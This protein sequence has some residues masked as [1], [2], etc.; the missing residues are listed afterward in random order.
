MCI[1]VIKSKERAYSVKRA[2]YIM[3]NKLTT[4]LIDCVNID[5]NLI[6]LN[7]KHARTTHSYMSAHNGIYITDMDPDPVSMIV[8][9][10]REEG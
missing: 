6:M 7:S 4:Y 2:S 10:D 3:S 9:L 5:F 8:F 1:M